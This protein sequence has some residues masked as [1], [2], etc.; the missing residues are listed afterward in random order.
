MLPLN[1][2]DRT[3]GCNCNDDGLESKKKSLNNQD[4]G[5]ETDL[6]ELTKQIRMN[7]SAPLPTAK[8]FLKIKNVV[9]LF[10]PKLRLSFHFNN[11]SKK[12]RGL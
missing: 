8:C 1:R 4:Q 12:R 6:N 5:D 9:H 2:S 3:L 7:K 11:I 10:S